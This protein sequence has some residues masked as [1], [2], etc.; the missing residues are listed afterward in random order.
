MRTK[1][2]LLVLALCLALGAAQAE[3]A[4]SVPAVGDSLHGFT[5]TAV[6]DYDRLD[7]KIVYLTHEKTGGPVIWVA[8]D[9]TERSFT[10]GFRTHY[11]NDKG[12]P[13]VFEHAALSGSES[14]PDS[15]LFFNMISNTCQTY[16]N[17]ITCINRTVYPCASISDAQ[18]LKFAD[19]YLAGVFEPLVVSDI[20]AM[21]REAYR[22]QLDSE[23]ADLQLTGTVYSEMLGNYYSAE[24]SYVMRRLTYPGSWYATCTGGQ[25]GVI[26][27]MTQ[28]DLIDY[29]DTYYQPSNALTVL[30]GDLEL[31]DFLE[32]IAKYYDR[33]EKTEVSAADPGYTPFTGYSEVSAD[34][35]ASADAAAD[36]T[37]YYVIPVRG[38]SDDDLTLF[39]S[40]L[41][42]ALCNEQSALYKLMMDRFP[43]ANFGAS[44][45][46]EGAEPMVLFAMLNAE[47]IASADFS[48]AVREGLTAVLDEGIRY[49]VLQAQV[50]STRLS[51]ATAREK[52]SI[53]VS[54]STSILQSFAVNGEADRYF[55]EV[56]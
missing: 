28:Q 45:L 34:V 11:D 52:S 26:E 29:H 48:A 4:H 42:A 56:K 37:L 5:V 9:D 19:V 47:G 36:T 7:A 2:I 24:G 54:L 15:Q 32:V 31:S 6:E 43:S 12:V 44:L 20:H 16:L 40:F 46:T 55:D 50:K 35:C 41:S 3:M 23:D 18:L 21:Q 30:Y 17:A 1:L 51:D 38:L 49:D 33:Y 53:G 39:S 22:Y 14:Y 13:H 10:I 8:D 27:T 25:P